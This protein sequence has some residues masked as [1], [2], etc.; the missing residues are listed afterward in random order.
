M[1]AKKKINEIQ[2]PLMYKNLRK[3]DIEETSLNIIKHRANII[4]NGTGWKHFHWH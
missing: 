2:Q 3:L 4:L 1:G